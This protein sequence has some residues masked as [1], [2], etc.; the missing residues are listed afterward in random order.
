MSHS[1][2]VSISN[3]H[4]RIKWVLRFDFYYEKYH[5]STLS[6]VGWYMRV[7]FVVHWLI[8]SHSGENGCELCWEERTLPRRDLM[9]EGLATTTAMAVTILVTML[10]GA[11]DSRECEI[12]PPNE[13]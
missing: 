5:T 7:V 8:H 13:F 3:L 11:T 1:L 2:G 12:S 4:G 9:A 6:V 10:E